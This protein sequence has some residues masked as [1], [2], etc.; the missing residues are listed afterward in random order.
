MRTLQLASVLAAVLL[1]P[2]AFGHHSGALFYDQEGRI[3]I[4][5]VVAKFNFRNPHAI[6]ELLVTT[7]GGDEQRWTAETAA[8][9]ALRRRGWSQQSLAPGE[10]VTLDGFRARD[11]SL[12][13]RITNVT[14]ADGTVVGVPRGVD[15]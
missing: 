12:L 9:S 3:T 14:R 2:P 10:T 4:T 6:V 1:G 7:D 11:G 5:G 15:N 8:P 13:M